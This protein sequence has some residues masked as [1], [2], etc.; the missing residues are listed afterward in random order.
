VEIIQTRK[1]QSELQTVSD[2]KTCLHVEWEEI[3][4]ASLLGILNGM[5]A[6]QSSKSFT[7]VTFFGTCCRTL[8]E[9]K[10]KE[11]GQHVKCK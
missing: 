9:K 1:Q 10:R 5:S 3:I 8:L 6:L 11:L 7:V 2:F 4:I